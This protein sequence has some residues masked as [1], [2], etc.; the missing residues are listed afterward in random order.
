[1]RRPCC[2]VMRRRPL[3]TIPGAIC[4]LLLLCP[5]CAL[6]NYNLL[7]SPQALPGMMRESGIFDRGQ[8]R[9][10]WI[11]YFPDKRY[12]LPGVLVHPDAAGFAEDME[13]VC[14]SLAQAGYFA[15]AVHYQR[16]E[17]L[18]EKNA[19][20]CCKSFEEG[21]AA[22]IHLLAHPRVDPERAGL[23]GFSK[24]GTHSLLIAAAEPRVKAAVVYYPL[25]DFEEWLNVDRYPFP[26]SL[27]VRFIRGQ[28]IKKRGAT[29]WEEVLS[30]IRDASP[31]NH[32]TSIQ[33]PILL[34]HGE[35]DRTVP[36]ADTQRFFEALR[37]AGGNCELYVLPEAGH[38]F[39]FKNKEQGRMAWERTLQF[40]DHHLK[41]EGLVHSPANLSNR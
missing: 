38:V 1:M 35:T 7:H 25:T 4:L 33:S 40:L 8:L 36:L 34:I 15:A 14:F 12:R 16:L 21:K 29:R 19:F 6:K 41:K 37:A 39:N 5:G 20:V 28:V 13:G 9:I 30:D 23:L 32:V 3:L 18:K 27:R 10:H 26:A 17:N 24:G 22:F 2:N 11:A 31:I